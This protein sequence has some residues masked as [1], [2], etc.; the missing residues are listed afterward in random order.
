M[1]T[2][3]GVRKAGF[4]CNYFSYRYSG[5]LNIGTYLL[6]HTLLCSFNFIEKSFAIHH[7]NTFCTNFVECNLLI[8]QWICNLNANRFCYFYFCSCRM[9]QIITNVLTGG[10]APQVE[11]TKKSVRR[12]CGCYSKSFS[13]QW[14]YEIPVSTMTFQLHTIAAST[15]SCFV[16]SLFHHSSLRCSLHRSYPCWLRLYLL[17]FSASC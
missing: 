8:V 16:R 1:S 7:S 13:I 4:H 10:L 5:K 9:D 6:M 2:F 3:Q 17:H 11:T 14:N 12:K 15:V